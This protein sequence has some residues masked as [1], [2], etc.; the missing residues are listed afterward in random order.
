MF[1]SFS[2]VGKWEILKI[3]MVILCVLMAVNQFI[4]ANNMMAKNEEK[5]I[6]ITPD[7][8][9][10]L[11][12]GKTVTGKVGKYMASF[13]GQLG[14]NTYHYYT[15]V[16]NDD[17]I[18]VFRTL[19]ESS[20]DFAMKTI[21]YKNIPADEP[22]SDNNENS[23]QEPEIQIEYTGIVRPM[24]DSDKYICNMQFVADNTLHKNDIIAESEDIYVTNLIYVTDGG[25]S[26]PVNTIVVTIIGGFVM[27]A[28]I[29]LIM[30]K[31]I[32]DIIYTIQVKNGTAPV[33][34]PEIRQEDLVFELEGF[35]EGNDQLG[36]DFYV[37]TEF[38]IRDQGSTDEIRRRIKERMERSAAAARQADEEEQ[39]TDSEVER[40][41][42][43]KPWVTDDFFYSSGIN[44]EGNFYVETDPEND[45]KKKY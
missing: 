20:F 21:E 14:D 17:R 4:A 31:T 30:R 32:K 6:A 44:E 12:V 40:T 37:N 42:P 45:V 27:L 10:Q 15:F 35:Y 2:A 26:I 39:R 29:P 13:P 23:A 25:E 33:P 8:Y 18:M 38:N 41:E 9:D 1:K 19:P 24:T 5:P 22:D 11:I 16:T 7:D 28:L 36:D 34:E 3:I 43:Q